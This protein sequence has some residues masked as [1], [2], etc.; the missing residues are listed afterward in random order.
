MTRIEVP[1]GPQEALHL[2][3]EDP[4]GERLERFVWEPLDEGPVLRS[5]WSVIISP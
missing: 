4:Q 2:P 1:E 3:L 5:V